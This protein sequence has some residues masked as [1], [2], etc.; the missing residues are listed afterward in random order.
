VTETETNVHPEPLDRFHTRR[1]RSLEVMRSRPLVALALLNGLLLSALLW[2]IGGVWAAA[3]GVVVTAACAAGVSR[4]LGS[5]RA[6]NDFVTAFA[7]TQGWERVRMYRLSGAT[8]LTREGGPGRPVGIGDARLVSKG[9]LAQG[10]AT[11]VIHTKTSI[12]RL[13]DWGATSIRRHPIDVFLVDLSPDLQGACLPRLLCDPAIEPRTHLSLLELPFQ[14]RLEIDG[15]APGDWDVSCSESADEHTV[16]ALFAEP[17]RGWLKATAHVGWGWQIEGSHLCTWFHSLDRVAD[18][19]SALAYTRH[20]AGQIRAASRRIGHSARQGD[21]MPPAP[22]ADHLVPPSLQALARR[23]R[24]EYWPAAE[25]PRRFPPFQAWTAECEDVLAGELAPGL[26]GAVSAV[27]AQVYK[28][29]APGASPELV[30]SRF[31]AAVVRVPEAAERFPWIGCRDR[32]GSIAQLSGGPDTWRLP[33]LRLSQESAEFASRFGVLASGAITENQLRQLFSPSLL[34][35]HVH[36]GL[37]PFLWHF[38]RGWLCVAWENEVANSDDLEQLCDAASR[39]ARSLRQ[40]A[41]E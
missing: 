31:L 10:D 36:V 26:A 4:W 8:A 12:G 32:R 23:R 13:Q 19:D 29:Q 21:W 15:L 30:K 41:G 40:E 17:F 39:I 37:E 25:P 34:L 1:G 5:R 24:L 16:R 35:W 2:V 11:T 6:L 20:V 3:A 14:R 38:E 28:R 7:T 27:T 22:A 33:R 18:L 9:P